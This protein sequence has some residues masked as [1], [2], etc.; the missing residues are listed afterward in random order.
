M[1]FRLL[2]DADALDFLQGLPA[3]QRRRLY[4]YLRQIQKYP[5]NYS[6]FTVRDDEGRLLDVSTYGAFRVYYWTDPADRHVKILEIK[7]TD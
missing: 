4:S 7:E 1:E 6:E 2:I 5:G 3:Q